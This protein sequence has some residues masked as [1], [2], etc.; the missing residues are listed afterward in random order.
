MDKKQVTQQYC[1]ALYLSVR[2]FVCKLVEIED[3]EL[4][5]CLYDVKEGRP[6]TE[7]HVVRWSKNAP[8]DTD[9]PRVFFTV[10]NSCVIFSYVI[11]HIDS[12]IISNLKKCLFSRIADAK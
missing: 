8:L 12:S 5:M 7:N 9:H 10:W 2:D 6:F 3:F 11:C 1:H 4:L